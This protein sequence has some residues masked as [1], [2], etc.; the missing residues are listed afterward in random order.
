MF[1]KHPA[2]DIV[3]ADRKYWNA[4]LDDDALRIHEGSLAALAKR[5]R[6][7]STSIAV[8]RVKIVIEAGALQ[9]RGVGSAVETMPESS[10]AVPG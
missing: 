9:D 5:H 1:E 8:E 4:V 10:E 7:E 6:H 3:Y 2:F